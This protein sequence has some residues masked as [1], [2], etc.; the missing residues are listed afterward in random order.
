MGKSESMIGVDLGQVRDPSAIAIVERA[1]LQGEWDPATFT[2]RK[3][4]VLRLRYLERV[5]LGTP[6]AEVVR[7]V[8]KMTRSVELAGR[9]RL[10]VDAT[11]VGRPVVE[12]L[13]AGDLG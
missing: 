9:F 2:Y 1:A 7:R 5:P 3:E 10:V 6:Y 11:G 8:R 4:V 12:L 13:R